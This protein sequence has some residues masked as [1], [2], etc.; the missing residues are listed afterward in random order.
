M[1]GL[2]IYTTGPTAQALSLGLMGLINH[3][4]TA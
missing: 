4:N 3:Q 1:K 2:K